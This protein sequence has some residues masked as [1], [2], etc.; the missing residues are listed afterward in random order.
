M[1]KKNF[2]LT[3]K[4][5]SNDINYRQKIIKE[6][7]LKLP[8]DG[9][10]IMWPQMAGCTIE[11]FRAIKASDNT[12]L[13]LKTFTYQLKQKG[14]SD[15]AIYTGVLHPIDL[16]LITRAY[17]QKNGI[18]VLLNPEGPELTNEG[19][20]LGLMTDFQYLTVPY[21]LIENGKEETKYAIT[22]H[23]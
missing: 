15:L 11:L 12:L 13:H 6:C 5:G 2:K 18:F 16:G 17:S 9:G 10:E 1:S 19:R 7:N 23:S 3:K 22:S 14:Y 8:K 4:D 21:I 20:L